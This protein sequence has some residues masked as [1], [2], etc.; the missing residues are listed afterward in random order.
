M[1]IYFSF[2]NCKALLNAGPRINKA[3]VRVAEIYTTNSTQV[4]SSRVLSC[5]REVIYSVCGFNKDES[6]GLVGQAAF[7]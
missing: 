3:Q 7:S 1:H 5:V 6:G 2:G 4:L